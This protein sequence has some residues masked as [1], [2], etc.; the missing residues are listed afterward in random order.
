MTNR[1]ENRIVDHKLAT[2]ML[3]PS[4]GGGQMKYTITLRIFTKHKP[5]ARC[6]HSLIIA[7][8]I[9]Q[10]NISDESIVFLWK[11]RGEK[12]TTIVTLNTRPQFYV[13]FYYA[14][15]DNASIWLVQTKEEFPLINQCLWL[16]S[17][18]ID[19]GSQTSYHDTSRYWQVDKGYTK[20][21]DNKAVQLHSS[22]NSRQLDTLRVFTKHNRNCYTLPAEASSTALAEVTYLIRASFYY[23]NYDG[24]SDPPTF[25]LELEGRKWATVMTSNTEPQFHEL[26]YYAKKDNISVCLVQTKHKQ[27]PFINVLELWPLSYLLFNPYD[28]VDEENTTWHTS[29][30]Y[31]YGADG[32][33]WILGYP[34]DMEDKIWEP[35]APA[36]LKAVSIP[37]YSICE[38]E[39]PDSVLHQAVEA[40]NPMDVIDL[41][42]TFNGSHDLQHYVR[43][44]FSSNINE[45]KTR[46]FGFYVNG[47]HIST[48]AINNEFCTVAQARVHSNGTLNV[49]LRPYGN[50]TSSPFIS[51]I[52]IYT[53]SSGKATKEKKKKNLGL[54]IG[55]PVGL[56]LGLTLPG[57][58]L[59]LLPR[60]P[61]TRPT[62]EQATTTGQQQEAQTPVMRSQNGDIPVSSNDNGDQILM[63]HGFDTGELEELLELHI[64]SMRA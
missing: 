1:C 42:F 43:A 17:V 8:F 28:F 10:N 46:T 61:N 38:E 45:S 5:A 21:G 11:F 53:A 20:T 12:W 44:Y 29:Y 22:P 64:T 25:D 16:I 35:N 63:I 54:L 55:L 3:L 39:V 4:P 31:R 49:Q 60:R 52:V 27:F 58:I 34:D 13:L 32:D 23:G 56:A 47:E 50:S 14:K 15:K 51:G 36:G 9:F 6:L 33:D 24:H 48:I 26:L 40:P 7:V 59:L 2:T 41:P 37:P 62:Q 19:C 57:L 18:S 30:R